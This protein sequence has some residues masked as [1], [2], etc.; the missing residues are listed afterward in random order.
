MKKLILGIAAGIAAVGGAETVR[1]P[2][3]ELPL[4]EDVDV[5]VV[6]GGFA[7]ASAALAAKEAGANVFVVM[8]RQNPGD[9]IASTRRLWLDAR[10]EIATGGL[11]DTVFPPASGVDFSYSPS[12]AAVEPHADGSHTILK[13][14]VFND[15]ANN[16]AQY[17]T[18]DNPCSS[19]T[20]TVSPEQSGGA[21][22]SVR[23]FYYVGDSSDY[24]K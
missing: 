11:A 12:V 1:E 18:K 20:L 13:D 3:R 21:I 15:A 10:D 22:L 23:L 9:D 14:G 19:V 2:A 17:G 5:A 6:G 8:P 16:S 4:I 7:A 24:G